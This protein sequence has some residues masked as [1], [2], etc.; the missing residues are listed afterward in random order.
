MRFSRPQASYASQ[1]AVRVPTG[2]GGIRDLLVSLGGA[3]VALSGLFVAVFQC[4]RGQP[5]ATRA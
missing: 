5:P 2:I 4:L 3:I 1:I